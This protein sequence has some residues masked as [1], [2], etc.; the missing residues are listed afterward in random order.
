[1]KFDTSIVQARFTSPLGAMIVAATARGLAGAWFEGQRHLPDSSG[2]P[3]QPEHPVL[4]KAIAQLEEYFG[5]RR[6]QFDLPLD[7]Q[8]GTAFQQSVWQALLAI[9][10]GGTTSY[11]TLSQRIGKP[12][13]V[14]AVGAAVGRNPMSIIVPCHRVLGAD[15]SLTGYAGGLE[16]KSALLQIEGALI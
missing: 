1:M 5:G 11:G 13:A 10:S 6:Q 3:L 8:G 12:A 15:G 14:R 7:L 9:P 4:R 2:W 16:R